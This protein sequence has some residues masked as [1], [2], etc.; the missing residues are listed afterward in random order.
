MNESEQ[1]I[2]QYVQ[3]HGQSLKTSASYLG[4]NIDDVLKELGQ[5]TPVNHEEIATNALAPL[6]VGLSADESVWP[7]GAS[8]WGFIRGGISSNIYFGAAGSLTFSGQMW[9]S[10]IGVGGGGAGLWTYTPR[11]GDQM[12]F[13]WAGIASGGGVV[14]VFWYF[15]VGVVIGTLQVAVAGA[16]LG[17]G[18]GEGT[19]TKD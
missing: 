4:R 12:N 6:N 7:G 10:P 11:G 14:N 17:G 16:A 18:K 15:Q 8:L 19:W 9:T 5:P 13:A 1:L 3:T 2:Q